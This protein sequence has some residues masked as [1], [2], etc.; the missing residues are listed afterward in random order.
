MNTFKKQLEK[1]LE[2]FNEITREGLINSVGYCAEEVG[3][4]IEDISEEM[5]I[6]YHSSAIGKTIVFDGFYLN[7]DSKEF[8]SVA[9][10]VAWA[11]GVLIEIK[12]FE[13][14]INKIK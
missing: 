11:D 5:H 2:Q 10:L 6:T 13:A 9:S 3:F 7:E 4:Y 14:R 12:D 8:E 1:E